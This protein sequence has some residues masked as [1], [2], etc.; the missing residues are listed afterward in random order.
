MFHVEHIV[1][2]FETIRRK[3]Q[4]EQDSVVRKT[5]A[6]RCRLATYY[7]LGAARFITTALHLYKPDSNDILH[8]LLYTKE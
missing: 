6:N 4:L 2:T 3:G 1:S 7:Y 5:T 8:K